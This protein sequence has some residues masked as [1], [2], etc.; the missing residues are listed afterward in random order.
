M[1]KL[2]KSILIVC[3]ISLFLLVSQASAADS[4]NLNISDINSVD[5]NY[6]V[7][8]PD[9][10]DS[11]LNTIDSMDS[12]IDSDNLNEDDL[13]TSI[14]Q[15]QFEEDENNDLDNNDDTE[16]I[17]EEKVKDTEGV[18]MA[19]DNY[20][21]GPASLATALNKL[22]LNLSLSEVSQHTNTTE[23]GTNMQSLIDAA[24]YYNFSAVGVEIEAKDLKENS[25]VHLN[26]EGGEHWTVVTKVTEDTIFLADSTEGN[27]NMSIDEF[28]SLFTGKAILLSK[29][30]EINAS[31]IISNKNIKVLDKSQCLNVK[32]R[33]W[34]RVLVGY[35]TVWK[36][37]LVEK[38]SWVLRPKV[39]KGHV[40]YSTWEYVYVK[41]LT[42]GKYKVKTPIYK[43]K[44]IKNQ[45][46]VKGKKTK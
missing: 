15:D 25:I 39:S 29:M 41:H 6:L 33:G 8:S 21:C 46:E 24:K 10:I 7:S 20:S 2:N 14:P 19:G 9:S 17:E 23:N 40:S 43:Y 16:I 34:V 36:Y 31:N 26:M 35:K 38:Y 45:Y 11:S 42:W 30:N 3:L 5:E 37:G 4:S 32:G 13:K 1:L 28:N 22:G 18:V 27:I 12:S 44:Y